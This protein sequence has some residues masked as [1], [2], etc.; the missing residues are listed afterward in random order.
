MLR[1]AKFYRL[2]VPGIASSRSPKPYYRIRKTLPGLG[3]D[4]SAHPIGE[5]YQNAVFDAAAR[6]KLNFH[7]IY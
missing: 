6:G 5:P 2:F 1:I 3:A 7:E 4:S